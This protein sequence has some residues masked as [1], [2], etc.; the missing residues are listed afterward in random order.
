MSAHEAHNP[1]NLLGQGTLPVPAPEL[2]LHGAA[3]PLL[4][5]EWRQFHQGVLSNLGELF[6]RA[7]VAKGL[8]SASFFK[9]SWVERKLPRR[10]IFAAALWH[11]AFIMMPLPE[12]SGP[13]RN[14]AFDNT[15]LTWSG[16]IEDLPL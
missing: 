9:D 3:E 11:I 16:A 6:H 1:L 10:A 15:Q 8:L 4:E 7:N 12:I 2:Q 14:H 5:I 13:R